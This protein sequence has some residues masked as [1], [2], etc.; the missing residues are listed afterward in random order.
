MK[1]MKLKAQAIRACGY[2]TLLSVALLLGACGGSDK[3]IK[4]PPVPNKPAVTV[5][6]T[7]K[8]LKFTWGSVAYANHYRLLKNEAGTSGY[9]QVG[10][11]IST[12]TATDTISV[13]LHDWANTRY[14]VEACNQTGCAESTPIATTDAMLGAIG[15][16]SGEAPLANDYMGYSVALSGDGLYM[17][18]GATNR[19]AAPMVCL[20]VGICPDPI[21]T[22]NTGSVFVFEQ[23]NG[24]WES[25]AELAVVVDTINNG[26]YFG[27]ALTLSA[28]GDT[29]AV[30]TPFESSSAQ[31]INGERFDASEQE[32][33]AVY[34]FKRTGD[35][36]AEQ[37]YIKASNAEEFDYFGSSLQL[38]ADGNTLV[39]G[40]SG[41]ESKATGLD[42]NQSD[43]SIGL[44]G[45]VYI[46]ER[47]GDTWSQ[48]HYL[49]AAKQVYMV[50][51]C[52]NPSPVRCYPTI[53]GG[54]GGSVSLS[55]DGTVLAVGAIH[56]HS[57]ATGVN[58]VR[59]NLLARRSG[60]TYVFA[61][62]ASGWQEE[63]YIKAS[64]TEQRDNFGYRVALSEDGSQLAA[65]SV[66]DN[67]STTGINGDAMSTGAQ[68]AGAVHVFYRTESASSVT[69]KTWVQSAY[70]KASNTGSSAEFG[71]AMA[72]S[73]NGEWLAVGAS[74]EKSS[75]AG[76]GGDQLNE[77]AVGAGAV[78]LF[79]R[80]ESTWAQHKYIKAPAPATADSFGFSLDLSDD[81][82]VLA[83][84]ALSAEVQLTG[85]AT[86]LANAGKVLVY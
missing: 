80:T 55:A 5:S 16:L 70:I 24:V 83:V 46:F 57:N 76:I 69:G 36:W 14:I 7:A 23:K 85:S 29:L 82:K 19:D 71:S 12:T 58:G 33:G 45:A 48:A 40:A 74:G 86:V 59:E 38:S 37:A 11:N 72:F 26:N 6:S 1:N 65:S 54:F 52:F 77:A 21:V 31:G 62:T 10:S 42:G 60:A 13:H 34:V 44:A 32:S 28:N 15:V 81:G 68:Y 22:S 27:Y 2:L 4:P 64:N 79:K 53:G 47:N 56:D 49:K 8:T 78:Y 18:V 75:A 41:E 84:G 51:E 3:K 50:N 17:A 9:T 61:K 39:V 43:N 20:A 25:Q 67:S 63:A 66:N 73:A 35:S 30:G